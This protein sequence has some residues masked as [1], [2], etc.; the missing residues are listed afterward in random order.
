LKKIYQIISYVLHPLFITWYVCLVLLFVCPQ[1]VAEVP[2]K[3]LRLYNIQIICNSILYP[4]LVVF[5]MWRIGFIK[6]IFMNEA[7]ERLGPLIASMLFFFWNYYVFYKL[8]EVPDVLKIFLLGV[9]L[10]TSILFIFTI[11]AKISMHATSIGGAL[12]AMLLAN[13]FYPCNMLIY[14]FIAIIATIFVCIARLQL[15]Q[16]TRAEIITGL[17]VGFISQFIALGISKLIA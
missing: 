12:A 11:F 8:T 17:L 16:H 9:F 5:I 1:V 3:D 4:G 10:S 14:F 13:Y 2:L 15:K 6:S 7:R